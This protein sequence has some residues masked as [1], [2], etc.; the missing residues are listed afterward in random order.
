MRSLETIRPTV[1][2]PLSGPTGGQ[3]TRGGDA[4]ITRF[5]SPSSGSERTVV[6]ITSLKR[7]VTSTEVEGM[8]DAFARTYGEDATR[9]AF[10]LIDSRLGEERP[11]RGEHVVSAQLAALEFV[12]PVLKAAGQKIRAE[13]AVTFARG[14]V[15]KAQQAF[16]EAQTKAI[17]AKDAQLEMEADRG[18]SPGLRQE[19]ETAEALLRAATDKLAAA[20]ERLAGAEKT[21]EKATSRLEIANRALDQSL[22]HGEDSVKL[23]GQKTSAD[24]GV[25]LAQR[26]LDRATETLAAAQEKLKQAKDDLYEMEQDRGWSPGLRMDRDKAERELETAKQEATAAR[27]ELDEAVEL[28]GDIAARLDALRSGPMLRRAQ[29]L[30]DHVGEDP[31]F[32]ALMDKTSPGKMTGGALGTAES[33][34]AS[35]APSKLLTKA[36]TTIAAPVGI[37]SLFYRAVSAEDRERRLGEVSKH[38]DNAPL[39][40]GL[41][42][43][44]AAANEM[45][46]WKLGIQGT[47]GFVGFAV[48]VP[49]ASAMTALMSPLTSAISHGV[50]SQGASELVGKATGSLVQ[51]GI[52][53]ALDTGAEKGL[54]KFADSHRQGMDASELRE[55]LA[56]FELPEGSALPVIPVRPFGPQH[57]ERILPLSDPE[58]ASAFL[59]YLGPKADDAMLRDPSKAPMEERR[60]A[61]R[62]ELF[63][64]ARDEN[65]VP[66]KKVEGD[67]ELISQLDDR[68]GSLADRMS[69]LHLLHAALGWTS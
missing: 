13:D 37:A 50:V 42:K 9:Q 17:E 40:K 35:L 8:R 34:M 27:R 38:L 22:D 36:V 6:E 3:D 7:E 63:G 67:G 21:L 26:K 46:K 52:K 64:A 12:S 32:T 20:K 18:W 25:E 23:E 29:A 61:M 24:R 16:D 43:S 5:T 28:Q 1:T 65:L 45:E 11:I 15:D 14:E 57:A 69:P 54:G 39:A 33:V 62:E 47:L 68:R 4:P 31:R 10:R 49:G 44:L 2:P 41:A 51:T 48:T 30:L 55:Q 53:K 60:L 59:A 19:R 66:G 56:K 58:V